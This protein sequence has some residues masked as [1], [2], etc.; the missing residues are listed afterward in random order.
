MVTSLVVTDCRICQMIKQLN[1]VAA[2][3]LDLK[4]RMWYRYGLDMCALK[5]RKKY[6][7]VKI[8]SN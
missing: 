6:L 3:V 2:L 7:E 5:R 4:S 1:K 8:W